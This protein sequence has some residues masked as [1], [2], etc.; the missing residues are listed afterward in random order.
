M[1]RVVK[2]LFQSGQNRDSFHIAVPFSVS[3][4]TQA[5]DGFSPIY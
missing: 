3:K 2:A 4:V 1:F 5:E